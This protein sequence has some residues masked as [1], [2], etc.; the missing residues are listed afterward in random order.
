MRAPERW[1]QTFAPRL[2]LL[3]LAVND[4]CD[5][6][7]VHCQIW[8]GAGRLPQLS[9]GERLRLVDEALDAGVDEALLTGGEPLLSAD[10]WRLAE[11]LRQGRARLLL[12]TSAGQLERFASDV[13]R[14]FDEIYI[15]LDGASAASH[16]AL[17]GVPTLDRVAA[18]I[19]ALLRRRPRPLIVARSALHAG[20]IHELEA[21]VSA[22]RELRCDHVSFLA[23]DSSSLAFGGK[24]AARLPLVPSE[25]QVAGYEAAVARLEARGALGDGFV[26]ETPAKLR[27]LARHFR[28]SAGQRTFER[29]ACDAPWWSLMVEADGRVRPCF[30]HEA[31]GESREGLGALRASQRYAAALHAIRAPNVTC[32]RCVCP[33]RRGLGPLARAW[34]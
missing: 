23:L 3:V 11:R 5:Q 21:I 2:R 26:L 9:L 16:D 28:A 24:P 31:V 20:N 29:P 19:V 27:S 17:R 33:K 14:L 15:S 7:C 18:G 6:R 13:A 10:L 25:A 32:E 12:A 8:Q 30:F 34:A 1:R 22:A 4:R